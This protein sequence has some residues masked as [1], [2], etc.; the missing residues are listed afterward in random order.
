MPVHSLRLGQEKACPSGV[1]AHGLVRLR[2]ALK[3]LNGRL[4]PI[5]ETVKE[6][7]ARSQRNSLG[8]SPGDRRMREE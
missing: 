2:Q 4:G 1:V 5:A 7:A 8:P 6:S 3:A